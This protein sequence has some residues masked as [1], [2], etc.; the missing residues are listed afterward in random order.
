MPVAAL[1]AF[2]S[3][4]QQCDSL[5]ANAHKVDA[6]GMSLFPARDQ[7]QITVAAFL[8]LFIAWESF[9][10]ACFVSLMTGGATISGAAPNRFAS[11]A[12]TRAAHAMI[13]GINRYFDFANIENV[14]KVAGIYFEQGYPFEPHLTA[15]VVDLTD[16]RTMRN[17]S[18]H[19]TSTTQISL[20]GLAQ[21]IL[22]TP[23]PGISLYGLLTAMHPAGAGQTVYA[24]YRDKLLAAAQ[25]VADG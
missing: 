23:Q 19:V 5:I 8:N 17:A 13:I 25:L 4:V 1:A 11:P 2:Q 24:T 22:G 18:A 9:L 12:S 6:T 3:E 20:E 10:E 14:R 7:Q 15:V 21:R 16:L